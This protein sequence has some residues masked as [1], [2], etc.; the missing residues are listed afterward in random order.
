MWQFIISSSPVFCWSFSTLPGPFTS[1]NSKNLLKIKSV[2]CFA[3]LIA[4]TSNP[5]VQLRL[6]PIISFLSPT[7]TQT[8]QGLSWLAMVCKFQD[9]SL[10]FLP[11][12]HTPLCYPPSSCAGRFC[13]LLLAN[14]IW[15]EWRKWTVVIKL[16]NQL[17]ELIKRKIILVGPELIRWD[18]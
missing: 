7:D 14:R 15:Q 4:P 13:D 12:V 17:T 6:L 1:P 10:W 5:Q 11:P 9:G 2:W 18:L 16:P 3:L 8:W